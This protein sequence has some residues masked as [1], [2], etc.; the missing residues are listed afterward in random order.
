MNNSLILN[1]VTLTVNI[2]GVDYSFVADHEF[3]LKISSLAKEAEKRAEFC[4]FIGCDDFYEASKFLSYAVDTLIG[5]GSSFKIFGTDFPDPIDICDVL[6]LIAD[7]FHSY[8]RERIYSIKGD[9][10]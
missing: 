8:R 7:V 10:V 9:R 4:A 6:G 3:A 1:K 5:E 2:N